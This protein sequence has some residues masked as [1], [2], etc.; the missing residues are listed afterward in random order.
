MNQQLKDILHL[1]RKRWLT[2]QKKKINLDFMGNLTLLLINILFNS[3]RNEHKFVNIYLSIFQTILGGESLCSCAT[4]SGKRKIFCNILFAQ[5]NVYKT[6]A[7]LQNQVSE[8]W[9]YLNDKE[10]TPRATFSKSE[11]LQTILVTTFIIFFYHTPVI[12]L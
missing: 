8:I 11:K 7:Q 3:R 6:W 12:N 5:K 4:R 10:T 1:F 2:K 9:K